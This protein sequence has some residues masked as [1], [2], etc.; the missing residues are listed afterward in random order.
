M[1]IVLNAMSDFSWNRMLNLTVNLD[2]IY[3]IHAYMHVYDVYIMWNMH[4]SFVTI[5]DDGL[6]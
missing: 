2:I 6:S 5:K 1:R 3:I 4:V